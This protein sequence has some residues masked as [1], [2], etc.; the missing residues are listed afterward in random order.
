MNEWQLRYEREKQAREAQT[1]ELTRPNAELNAAL[2][3]GQETN[4]RLITRHSLREDRPK[5]RILIAEDNPVSQKLPVYDR[6]DALQRIDNDE[7][8]LGQLIDIFVADAPSYLAEIDAAI[9]AADW[10]RLV[11]A[12]HTLKSVLATFSARRGEDL[13]RRLETAA[14]DAD[15]D[16][17]LELLPGLKTET[18]AFLA[19]LR[20]E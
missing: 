2:G 7:E 6:V 19:V 11:S 8:L 17:V 14:R 13:A 1:L 12:A 9:V 3:K 16:V 10:G 5:P 4:H 20:G 15:R 18:E